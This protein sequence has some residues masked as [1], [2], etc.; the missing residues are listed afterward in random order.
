METC[1][2]KICLL[3]L[4]TGYKPIF[5]AARTFIV[6]NLKGVLAES[7]GPTGILLPGTLS[8]E[9][10]DEKHYPKCQQIWLMWPSGWLLS[11][12]Y[13]STELQLRHG[14]CLRQPIGNFN[15]SIEAQEGLNRS[16][17]AR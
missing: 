2:L 17:F 5:E 12:K 1:K 16:A 13:K 10:E 14:W 7:D 6:D 11:E 15:F 8:P 3:P 4:K 9:E